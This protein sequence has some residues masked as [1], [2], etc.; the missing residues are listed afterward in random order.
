MVLHSFLIVP[1]GDIKQSERP[2]SNALPTDKWN[3]V[4]YS[5]DVYMVFKWVL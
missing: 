4:N 1:P 3:V 5:R 2:A